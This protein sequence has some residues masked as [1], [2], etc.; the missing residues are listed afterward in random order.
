[1]KTLLLL[2]LLAPS[3]LFAQSYDR[4]PHGQATAASSV[5]DQEPLPI[6]LQKTI[7]ISVISEC[8][9]L[10]YIPQPQTDTVKFVLSVEEMF[11]KKSYA[12]FI[13]YPQMQKRVIL[14]EDLTP[15]VILKV[16]AEGR[17]SS[18]IVYIPKPIKK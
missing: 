3:L 17:K 6:Q 15:G 18:P 14:S 2:V 12:G 13:A 16:Y 9:V 11:D 10:V 7:E 4:R 8:E 5:M 1:M